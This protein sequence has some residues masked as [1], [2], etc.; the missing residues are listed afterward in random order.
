MDKLDWFEDCRMDEALLE[1]LIVMDD[2]TGID[3]NEITEAPEEAP[4]IDLDEDDEY[5]DEV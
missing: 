2:V 4:F 3:H 5:V 1:A